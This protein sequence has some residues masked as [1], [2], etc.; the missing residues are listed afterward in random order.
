MASR[1]RSTWNGRAVARVVQAAAGQGN[2][3]AASVLRD[4][5]VDRVPRDTNELA[6]SAAV[7]TENNGLN[8]AVSFSGDHAAVQHEDMTLEHPGGGEAKFLENAAASERAAM[9][10][11]AA[12]PL[13]RALGS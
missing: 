7:S 11:A 10:R 4:G 5:A 9:L 8:A 6:E 3:D 12:G 2:T 13:R 1:V